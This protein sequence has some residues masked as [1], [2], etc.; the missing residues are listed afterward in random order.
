MDG[1]RPRLVDTVG[2][3]APYYMREPSDTRHMFHR[4]DVRVREIPPLLD[5]DLRTGSRLLLFAS[6]QP[7]WISMVIWWG[8]AETLLTIWFLVVGTV[9]VLGSVMFALA[10]NLITV[11]MVIGMVMVT[12]LYVLTLPIF[13]PLVHFCALLGVFTSAIG[14][15]EM[16]RY[17]KD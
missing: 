9:G 16:Y 10:R 7:L 12:N 4:T 14:L 11:A 2:T 6:V 17:W 13:I 3:D 5:D 1:L 15:L 8:P